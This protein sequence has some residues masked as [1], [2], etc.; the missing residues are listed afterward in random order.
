MEVVG[1]RPL[2]K[3][4]DV[5]RVKSKIGTYAYEATGNHEVY[6]ANKVNDQWIF[7]WKRTDELQ[8]NIDFLT[9]PKL[10]K[11]NFLAQKSLDTIDL[12]PF[13]NG[14][15][16]Q[17][18]EKY[19]SIHQ[20]VVELD[21][22][23]VVPVKM[24]EVVPYEKEVYCLQVEEDHSFIA[25][26]YAVSNCH[27]CRKDH[28]HFQRLMLMRQTKRTIQDIE[29]LAASGTTD[30]FEL[31]DQNLWMKTESELNEKWES[32][33][34]EI[35]DYELYKQSKANTV[36]ICQKAANVKI[37]RRVKLPKFPDEELMLRE[38]IEKG[39]IKRMLPNTPEYNSRIKEELDLI[40]EK[41]FVSYFLIQ[42]MMIDEARRKCPELLGFGDGSEAV[43]PGRGSFC[44]SLVAYCLE[45]HD[46]EPIKHGLLF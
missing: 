5:Y 45:L 44:G 36:A 28:S 11:K 9:I 1:N 2:K 19:D 31:Q 6:I 38:E 35:I 7:N 18:G 24:L 40:C 17:I 20:C 3:L 29:I 16:F 42:K 13:M 30:L 4:E 14:Y 41:G 8:A 33:Y 10:N 32:D 12:I 39:R 37:D 21:D 25:N 43:G 34:S 15:D 22:Y 27:Y 26:F 46:I 23:Y